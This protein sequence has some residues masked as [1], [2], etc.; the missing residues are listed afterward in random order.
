[1]IRIGSLAR[2]RS[3]RIAVACALGAG[4]AVLTTGL[5]ALL[6]DLAGADSKAHAALGSDGVALATLG[7]LLA[8]FVTS[9]ASQTYL[10]RF[11]ADTIADL[12][13]M[14]AERFLHLDFQRMLEIGKHRVS[15]A[16]MGDVQQLSS[17]MVVLPLFF[18]NAAT[19]VCLFGYLAVVSWQ[20]FLV[21]FG[22]VA[23]AVAG[24][25]FAIRRGRTHFR[26]VR[27][28]EDQ[29]FEAFTALSEGKKELSLNQA[30][31]AHFLD[32]VIQPS[33]DVARAHSFATQSWWNSSGITFSAL[34]LCG[35]AAVI[36][37]GR[38]ALAL[39][40]LTVTQAFVVSLFVLNPASFL[41]LAWRDIT[42]GM[43]SVS[44]LDALGVTLAEVAAPPVAAPLAWQRI[45]ARGVR[46]R[47]DA[48][49]HGFELG[50]ID[51]TLG[52][53]EIVFVVGGN[54]SGKSTLGLLLAGLL[55]PTGGQIEVD[56]RAVGPAEL[57]GYRR[58]FSAV[59]FDFH[60]FRH[61]V[62]RTGAPAADDRVTALLA[63]LELDARVS[64]S[65]GALSTLELSQGQR[66]R[67]ALV[68]AL[69]DEGD[70][71]LF[72]EWAADQDP[73]FKQYFYLELLPGLRSRGK[74]V[75]AITHDDRYFRTADRVVR[76]ES[77]RIASPS[78]ALPAAPLA[79]PTAAAEPLHV[80]HGLG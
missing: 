19:L 30:R 35:M 40:E 50:P 27:A 38:V 53:G 24:S 3:G 69:I 70:I 4:S 68:Q 44:R 20:L 57:L 46:H 34:H 36:Y 62:D 1:M 12:R 11:S 15:N 72:D 32:E 42:M 51:F 52:R 25:R 54:G 18:F 73:E 37:L 43:T 63:R 74:S 22:F 45:D 75:I 16:L 14:L 23:V 6:N 80:N 39:P 49:R 13:R 71:F 67:L 59:F 64:V 7:L 65:R 9:V 77:G 26:Q 66:K 60:L 41:V 78:G 55:A 76:L 47:Y 28:A 56:G 2:R 31:A 58:L 17:L 48:E 8:S 21:M 33:L 61:V 5:L 29:L 10:A 79:T